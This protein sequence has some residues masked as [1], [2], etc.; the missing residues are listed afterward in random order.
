MTSSAPPARRRF[1]RSEHEAPSCSRHRPRPTPMRRLRPRLPTRSDALHALLAPACRDGADRERRPARS[2]Q[3]LVLGAAR[4]RCPRPR[5]LAQVPPPPPGRRAGRRPHP[6]A[7][8][9]RSAQRHG[10]ASPD[11]PPSLLREGLRP[12]DGDS[13]R[14]GAPNRPPSR[15][16]P[17]APRQRSPSRQTPRRAHQPPP[18]HPSPRRSPT[19]RPA[20]R[21]R[22]DHRRDAFILRPSST[23]SRSGPSSGNH[24]FATSVKWKWA[25][26][27]PRRE[28]VSRHARPHPAA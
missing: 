16:L 9:R 18:G 20:R 6:V 1:A 28:L 11:S 3:S 4:G 10:R 26:G 21:R 24:V 8:A 17:Q 19:Q 15:R 7:C 12:G 23:Q 25:P 22:P 14:V 13:S 5:R 2:R 27:V